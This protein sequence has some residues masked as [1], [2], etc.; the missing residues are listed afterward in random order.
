MIHSQKKTVDPPITK[1]C[2]RARYGNIKRMIGKARRT[3]Y[4][5]KMKTWDWKLWEAAVDDWITDKKT[6]W[7]RERE[8]DK[9]AV[10]T[11]TAPFYIIHCSGTCKSLKLIY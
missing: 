5:T 3:I 8:R 4:K 11:V 6:V 1:G 10:A 7:E 2:K 9:D